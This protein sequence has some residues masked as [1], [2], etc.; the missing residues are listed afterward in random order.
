MQNKNDQ[1]LRIAV[2]DDSEYSRKSII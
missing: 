2:V 1:E